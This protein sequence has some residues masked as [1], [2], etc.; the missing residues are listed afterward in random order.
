MPTKI[1]CCQEIDKAHRLLLHRIDEANAVNELAVT[2]GQGIEKARE[3]LRRNGHVGVENHQDV[4]AR[5]VK[6]RAYGIALALTGLLQD[7][8]FS[9]RM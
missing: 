9:V 8:E 6:P 2:A 1:A 5:R 4:A 3:I 7:P